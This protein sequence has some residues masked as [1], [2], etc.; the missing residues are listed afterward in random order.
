MRLFCNRLTPALGATATLPLENGDVSEETA[1]MVHTA[2][3]EHSVLI[4]P[5]AGLDARHLVQ[6]GDALG[7]LGA[8]HHSYATH[9]DHEDVVVLTWGGEDKPDAA[10]WHSDMTYRRQPPFASILQAV[11]VPPVGGDTLWAGMF[12]VHDALDPGLRRD[13][14]QLEAVHDMGAFR[15]G[16]YRQGGDE[17]ISEALTRA[18]TAVH[19]VIAH[20]PVTGRPYVNVSESFTRFVIGLS[21]PESARILTYLFDL[22]NRPDF[23]VRLKWEAGT[24]VLWD[25]R[26]TQHYAVADY[27]PHRRVMHRV[28]VTADKR[29]PA[30]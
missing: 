4:F 13:L 24:V 14:E 6:L 9:P 10:E 20:H 15:T 8:R 27:L 7:T 23:H 5:N 22:I 18:G 30:G 17:G 25:N 26:G 16:A 11:E 28:A 29:T 3:I 19:P 12:A 21:A 2:L 1:D